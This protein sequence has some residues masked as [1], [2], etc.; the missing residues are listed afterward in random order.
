MV[1]DHPADTEIWVDERF[2]PTAAPKLEVIGTAIPRPVS[3][4]TGANGEDVTEILRDRD[5]VYLD[6]F[7]RGQYQG[8]TRD[9]WVEVSLEDAP[10]GV[11]LYLIA[12][13][14][15]HPTDSSIN[16]ALGQNR[17]TAPPQGMSIETPDT[18]GRWSVARPGLGFP[19]GKVKTVVLRV[20]DTFKTNA[21]RRLRIRTNLEIFWDQISWAE[22]K[23]NADKRTQ[24]LL[25][26]EANLRYRG[27]SHVQ[28]KD[29]SSPEIPVSYD[30][31]EGVAPRWRDLIGFHTRY[32]DV[33]PLM[34]EVDDRY[35]MLNAGD[36]M[37]LRF[38]E[39]AP[40]PP[41]WKR[42]YVVIG[43]G[44]EKDGNINTAWG[45]TVMPYPTHDIK[46]Y[47]NPPGALQDDPAYR[48]H[49]Q[50]WDEYHT[51]YVTP[52]NFHEALLPRRRAR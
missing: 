48:R 17:T 27:F 44:W 4:A 38:R 3:K 47:P 2:V 19:E 46:D 52:D 37:Q 23:P 11:P 13:G 51:R 6:D 10:R 45:K 43:D 9:H 22:A 15:L 35:V 30:D 20:D 40:P 32:G 33:L 26:A 21:P 12:H 1:V 18:Q 28:A 29:P 34:T 50:D 14:W 36:E 42:D 16:V 49:P 25:A 5:G 8:V 31:L 24:R 39:A 7:G 41:G